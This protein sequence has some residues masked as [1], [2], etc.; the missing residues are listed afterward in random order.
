[1]R[2]YKITYKTYTDPFAM[3]EIVNSIGSTEQTKKE[4]EQMHSTQLAPGVRE[5]DRKVISIQEV[6]E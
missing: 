1:M 5:Y 4:Y 6:A 3:V 2:Q